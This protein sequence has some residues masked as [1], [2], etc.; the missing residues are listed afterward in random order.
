MLGLHSYFLVGY[1][2]EE[3]LS[4]SLLELVFVFL[5][6]RKYSYEGGWSSG[7]RNGWGLLK[8]SDGSEYR[9]K[10]CMVFDRPKRCRGC[11][12]VL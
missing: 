5:L 6:G 11:R 2:T 9:G 8:C 7:L 3:T 4:A 10:A 1:I 12:L